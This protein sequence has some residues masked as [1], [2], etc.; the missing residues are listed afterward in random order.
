[1]STRP[2]R[3]R[4]A[5]P[6]RTCVGCGRDVDAAELVRLV[7]EGDEAVFDLAGGAFGRGAHVHASSACLAAAPRGLSRAFKREMKTDASALG[8]L[9][10]DACDRRMIGLLLAARRT[11]ALAVGT[12]ESLGALRRGDSRLAIIAVDAGVIVKT[13]EVTRAVAEGG[14][15][16]WKTKVDL[17]AILGESTVAI[18]SVLHEGFAAQLKT[19]RAAADAGAATTREGARCSS[20]VPEAR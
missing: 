7:V 3:E 11:R 19:L 16:A 14:V 13:R 18:C 10:A 5:A 8:R 17:G 15:I 2:N 1:M 9:L 20:P 4:R 12:D 6:T